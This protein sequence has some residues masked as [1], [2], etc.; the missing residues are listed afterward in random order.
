MKITINEPVKLTTLLLPLGH[1]TLAPQNTGTLTVKVE[2]E[3]TIHEMVV[4]APDIDSIWLVSVTLD[5]QE[6]LL[7]GKSEIK[8]LN[9][10]PLK[11]V[12]APVGSIVRVVFFNR[13]ITATTLSALI[14][15]EG[16]AIPFLWVEADEPLCIPAGA[17]KEFH[18]LF[19]QDL[20]VER[21]DLQRDSGE[22]GL[23]VS[24]AQI[25]GKYVFV[26]EYCCFSPKKFIGSTIPAG[27]DLHLLVINT[28][29]DDAMVTVTVWGRPVKAPSPKKE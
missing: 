17:S 6:L 4:S 21:L 11:E 13:A 8:A 15:G 7:R 25:N 23:Q 1:T 14:R 18:L 26:E 27:T 3:F 9:G 24:T 20:V 19:D 29:P 28:E 22:D 16:Q 12:T 2:R 5:G 10:V